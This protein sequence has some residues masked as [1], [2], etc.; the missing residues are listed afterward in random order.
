VTA[1]P[2]TDEAQGLV[3]LES[4]A[5]G[6]P[7]VAADSGAPP[8]I[9]GDSGETGLLFEPGDL[10]GLVRALRGAL[11]LAAGPQTAAACRARA[12]DFSWERLLPE[13]EA[14]Y[15]RAVAGGRCES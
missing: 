4:L 11:D 8:E 2:S 13:H 10:A 12:E 3:L 5:C 1:L 15:E 6:T 9:L 7:C 14:V